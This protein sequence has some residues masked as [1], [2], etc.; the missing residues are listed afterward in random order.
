MQTSG[1]LSAFRAMATA[2]FVDQCDT[3]SQGYYTL[4]PSECVLKP[5]LPFECRLQSGQ[6]GPG[7]LVHRYI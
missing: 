3:A 5:E 4:K 1:D 6:A 7:M 2:F